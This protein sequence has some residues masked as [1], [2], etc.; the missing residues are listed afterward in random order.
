[1][2]RNDLRSSSQLLLRSFL[3]LPLTLC[4]VLSAQVGD[5]AIAR[6]MQEAR[7]NPAAL[8]ATSVSRVGQS[9]P[10]RRDSFAL[11]NPEEDSLPA[12]QVLEA[13]QADDSLPVRFGRKLFSNANPSL[14]GAATGA[15]GAD[16]GLGPGDELILTLWGDRELRQ[17]QTID[18]DGQ[19]AFD[20]VGAISLSGKTLSQ[21]EAL[22]RTRLKRV[23]SGMGSSQHMDL[24]M[25]KLK[26]IRVFVVGEAERPGAYFLSGNT[27]V[28]AAL[29]MGGG[30]SRLGTE[31][32]V[33]VRHGDR[34]TA[35]DLYDL[36][37]QGKRPS[38]DGLQDG[39]VVRVPPHGPL[40]EVVG[41][42]RRP[43]VYEM[44]PEEDPARLLEYVGGL[45][46]QAADQGLSVSRIFANGRRDVV[47]YPTPSQLLQGTK[48]EPFRDGDEIRFFAGNDPSRSTVAAQG[49][50]R[51]PG[52]YPWVA[53]MTAQDL[54]GMAGG[55]NDSAF[56]GRILVK[57]VDSL[58]SLQALRAPMTSCGSLLLQM[59][60]TLMVF[61][62][63]AM[64]DTDSVLISGAVRNPGFFRYREG[65]TVKDL[66]L[67]AG[68]FLPSAEF[69]KV[70][71]EEG[72]KDSA[73]ATTV[74]LALDSSLAAGAADTPL[75]PGQHL[76]IPWNPRWYQPEAVVLRGWVR[77]PGLYFLKHPGERLSSVLGRAGG[78]KEGGYARAAVF[79]RSRDDVG[80]I[81]VDVAKALQNPDERWD[82]PLRGGDTLT[83]PDRPA[84]VRVSGY[85]NYPTS[86]MYEKGRSWKWYLA[87]AGGYADSAD[88]KKVWVRYADGSIL[89]RDYGLE[90]PDPGSELVVPKAPPPEKMRTAEK[91]QIFGSIASTL[92][93]I[94]TLVLLLKN[95]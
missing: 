71:L 87:R 54:L 56:E 33:L 48:A 92:L 74:W 25:G 90:N 50:V 95:S 81:Q 35:F 59:G 53:G 24:T 28:L 11:P 79:V 21:A 13:R 6:A 70:R 82:V 80:R 64:S 19:V 18:R 39:D 67:E 45:E 68:G 52:G 36:L 93:T 38:D 31:R 7:N 47:Q 1:M 30:P 22:L 78:I 94:A 10:T 14:F 91:V 17:V 62:R 85:V 65:M 84:T 60:D 37:F 75:E 42:A 46:A 8:R 55:P 63:R 69:G 73:V 16:Y 34:E 3:L 43:G 76:A 5:A 26:R 4:G 27:S 77:R 40:V 20:G 41:A 51:F 32:R 61:N 2:N 66:I 86:I 15:V 72:L 9:L 83:I 44:L 29:Y 89:S 12:D 58:G 23:Y 57:R 49:A 88:P